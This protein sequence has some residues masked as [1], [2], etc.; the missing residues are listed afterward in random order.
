M[1]RRSTAGAN[2]RVPDCV[3]ALRYA[4]LPQENDIDRLLR[5]T[6]FLR[7]TANVHVRF[8]VVCRLRWIHIDAIFYSTSFHQRMHF[9]VGAIVDCVLSSNP[10]TNFDLKRIETAWC[11]D[12]Q[13]LRRLSSSP[14]RIVNGASLDVDKSP[15]PSNTFLFPAVN[16]TSPSRI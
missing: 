15:L 11:S 14:P 12:D 1:R 13:H 9:V 3:R 8:G 4:P 10:A 7:S 5:R 16:S 2:G 6:T